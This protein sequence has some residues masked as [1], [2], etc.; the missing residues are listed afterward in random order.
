MG[1]DV[2]DWTADKYLRYLRHSYLEPWGNREKGLRTGLLAR[3]T[4]ELEDL[5]IETFVVAAPTKA[6]QAEREE[7]E[8]QAA[9][10]E[11]EGRKRRAEKGDD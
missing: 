10:F 3:A 8:R 7:W 11:A 5:D 6:E 2:S 1:E 9:E 4:S